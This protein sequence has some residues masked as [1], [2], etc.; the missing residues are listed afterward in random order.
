MSKSYD[1]FAELIDKQE[2]IFIGDYWPQIKEI[3][4]RRE[5]LSPKDK[6]DAE[7][8]IDLIV[9]EDPNEI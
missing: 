3:L 4:E 6:A 8:I 9:Y 5:H 1:K 2:P 7:A